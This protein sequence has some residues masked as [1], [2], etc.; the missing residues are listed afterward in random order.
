M[1][2]Y[3]VAFIGHRKI[4]ETPELKKQ[5]IELIERLILEKSATT[6]LFGSR[7]AFDD[8]CY[9]AVTKLKARYPQIRRVYVR[10]EYENLDKMYIDLI[11]SDYEEK[12]FPKRVRNAGYRSYIQRNRA[13]IDRCDLAIM[14]YNENIPPYIN[15]NRLQTNSGTKLAFE[16]A[17]KQN[18]PIINLYNVQ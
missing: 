1:E 10:S 13:M 14:Y 3:T 6:F 11:L 9:K 17:K 7:S 18:K 5:L 2:N 8:L 12:E 4:N 15:R 16:Y